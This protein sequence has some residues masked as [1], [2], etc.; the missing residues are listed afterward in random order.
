MDFLPR[1]WV[2]IDLEAILKNYDAACNISNTQIIPV[3]KANA[4]GHGATEVALAL[5]KRGVKL[6]A[7][8][9]INEAIQLREADII[10]DILVLGYTPISA[11]KLLS[12]HNIIQAVFSPLFAKELNDAAKKNNVKIRTHLK[13]DTGM[14]RI[15]FN[16]KKE[17]EEA[18]EALTLDCLE[19][20][21]VFTHFSCADSN[22]NCDVSYT[23]KQYDDFCNAIKNLEAQG[24]SFKMKHCSNSA[25]I[26]S[27]KGINLDAA[28][29][30][31]IL[32][33]LAPS[34]DVVLPSQ[35]TPAMSFYAAVSMVKEV[36]KDEYFSYGRTFKSDSVRKIATVSAGYGDGVPRLLSGNGYVL[37]KG[38]KAN[39]VGRVCMDQFLI[40]VTHIDDVKM[41]DIVTIFGKDL[42]VDEVAQ[43]A[44]TI[45]YEI[46]C[47]ITARVPRI[48][49]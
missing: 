19:N 44:Q 39:I 15:G 8:S 36:E 32:Y 35:F 40:D 28:R 1:A 5:S 17:L 29:E 6:F 23:Q 20:E 46:V 16:C 4:Y 11:A 7:V 27:K 13:L 41:G 2:Q 31:I 37:I 12:K 30:G 34:K 49:K 21:G 9:N 14:G 38:Q 48:Y 22:E 45:N 43:K 47:G 33:G 10:S 25:A 26:M 3:I 42:S 24:F 18:K